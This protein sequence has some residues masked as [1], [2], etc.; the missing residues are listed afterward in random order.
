[1]RIISG[2]RR[3]KKLFAPQNDR[4]RPTSDRAREALFSILESMLPAPLSEYDF[5]DVFAGTGAVGL[6]AASRGARSVTFIDI[7]LDLVKKNADA[8]RLPHLSYVLKDIRRLPPADRQYNLVFMD[9]PYNME[10]SSFA[11]LRLLEKGWLTDD[12][13]IIVETA[14]MELL[15]IPP[16]LKISR[17][18]AYFYGAARF[19]FVRVD[20]EYLKMR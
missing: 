13:I 7:D 2:I 19:T 10:L 12:T 1:M 11:L 5:L 18:K 4:I 14:K 6:E 9:A 15:E 16:G 8:C 17:A 3:G 20:P